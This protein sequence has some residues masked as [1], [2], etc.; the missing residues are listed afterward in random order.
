LIH[1]ELEGNAKNYARPLLEQPQE[2]SII[3]PAHF[4]REMAGAA[5][6]KTAQ[7][8]FYGGRETL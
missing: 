1:L 3:R 2:A 4:S 5:Q 8:D 7:Q 6:A